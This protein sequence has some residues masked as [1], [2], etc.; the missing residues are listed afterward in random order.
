MVEAEELQSVVG[1]EVPD[2]KDDSY[3][4]Q[5]AA[6]PSYNPTPVTQIRLQ[7]LALSQQQRLYLN[8]GGTKFETSGSTLQADPSSL[9]ALM[10]LPSSPLKPYSVDN[11][12][13]YFLDRDPK[14]FHYILTYLRNGA[15][16]PL[17]CL[18][19]DLPLLYSLQKETQFFSL[20]HLDTIVQK[21]I[22]EI[23]NQD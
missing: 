21:K 11:I 13:T 22:L 4:V 6:G 1:N 16:L 3:T 15:E 10:I 23:A 20:S 7:G 19:R 8:V 14:L 5:P 17:R 9:L 12:Y 18:P 2:H